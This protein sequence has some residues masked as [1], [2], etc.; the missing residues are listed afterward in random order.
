MVDQTGGSVTISHEMGISKH[1]DCRSAQ[2][3]K[4]SSTR[5]SA[6]DLGVEL[7]LVRDDGKNYANIRVSDGDRG[8]GGFLLGRAQ[9]DGDRVAFYLNPSVATAA[10]MSRDEA[11]EAL[12]KRL[13]LED[14]S[15]KAVVEQLMRSP[16]RVWALHAPELGGEVYVTAAETKEAAE[17]S[18]CSTFERGSM[19]KDWDVY[20]MLDIDSLPKKIMEDPGN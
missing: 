6:T 2:K 1:K 8:R 14:D 13:V 20:R 3:D 19:P 4:R 17:R 5:V 15:R 11:E 7:T 12:E 18:F 16:E 10:Y 9:R